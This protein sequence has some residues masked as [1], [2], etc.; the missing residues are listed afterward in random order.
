MNYEV[1]EELLVHSFGMYF[2]C[3]LYLHQNEFDEGPNSLISYKPS[4]DYKI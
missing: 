4:L 1:S 2:F 3:H